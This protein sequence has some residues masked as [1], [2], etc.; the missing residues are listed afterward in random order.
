MLMAPLTQGYT[1]EPFSTWHHMQAVEIAKTAEPS[2]REERIAAG[3]VTLDMILTAVRETNPQ[4]FKTLKEDIDQA[5]EAFSTLTGL[6]DEKCGSA[7]PPANA[8]RHAFEQVG[9][10]MQEILRNVVLPED[11][12]AAE[13]A[14]VSGEPGAPG[15]PAVATATGVAV[16]T[17]SIASRDDAFRALL[18]IADFFRR[19]EPHSPISYTL[20]ELVRRGRMPLGDLLA[21]LIPDEEARNGFL[22]RAGIEPPKAS[23]E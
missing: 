14:A 7:A 5:R 8:I 21:E 4:F 11:A 2:K 18:K 3:G 10:A 22:M 20:E 12:G 23:G 15:Q 19:S 9:E 17:D 6:V 1:Y 16:G 13:E